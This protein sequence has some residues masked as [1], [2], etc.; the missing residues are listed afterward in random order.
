MTG[1][2]VILLDHVYLVYLDD[3]PSHFAP[4]NYPHLALAEGH[5]PDLNNE[6]LHEEQHIYASGVRSPS[7][8]AAWRHFLYILR[9]RQSTFIPPRN[10][11][12]ESSYV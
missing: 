4:S 6:G 7:S 2:R 11:L 3:L 8:R 9:T 1:T 5:K 12:D 10:M